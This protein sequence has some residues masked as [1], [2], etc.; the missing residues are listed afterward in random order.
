MTYYLHVLNEDFSVIA[1][2]RVCFVRDNVVDTNSSYGLALDAIL[3]DIGI[4][5]VSMVEAVIVSPEVFWHLTRGICS[6]L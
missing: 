6:T 1:T 4:Q 3:G 2:I 5:I